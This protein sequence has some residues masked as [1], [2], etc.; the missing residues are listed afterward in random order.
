MVNTPRDAPGKTK[1][2]WTEIK[3][4]ETTRAAALAWGAAWRDTGVTRLP[5]GG[6][7][8]GP[9]LFEEVL[10]CLAGDVAGQIL[11]GLVPNPGY[12]RSMG[13][14][15]GAYAD[16]KSA[17]IYRG[18]DWKSVDAEAVLWR[19]RQVL[20]GVFQQPHIRA[21]VHALDQALITTEQY[22]LYIYETGYY[23]ESGQVAEIIT[24]VTADFPDASRSS[25]SE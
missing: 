13:A 22:D 7:L 10:S 9:P 5:D 23:L 16:I 25:R 12:D 8:Y 21:I 14:L 1:L 2:T 3:G 20:Y 19:C 15:R 18:I 17:L 6:R 24:Q 4:N 11:L